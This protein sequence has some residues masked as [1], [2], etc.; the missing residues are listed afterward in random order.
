[1]H[2]PITDIAGPLDLLSLSMFDEDTVASD[3]M[4][5]LGGLRLYDQFYFVPKMRLAWRNQMADIS[6]WMSP[7]SWANYFAGTEAG[8]ILKSVYRGTARFD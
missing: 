3:Y 1:M 7:S 4:A 5:A 2:I 6:T 8:N